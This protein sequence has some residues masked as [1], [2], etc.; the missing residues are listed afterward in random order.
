VLITLY[1][2]SAGKE[3][4][5]TTA[6][7]LT[8]DLLRER[9]I[10]G[11]YRGTAATALRDVTFSAIYFPLFANLNSLGPKRDDGQAVFYWSFLSGCAAGSTAALCVNPMDVIKTRL[12]A[13]NPVEGVAY[14]GVADCIW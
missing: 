3:V 7:Q 12:Q 5:Q 9:G 1:R 4:V 10:L 8:R 14:N 6:L 13:I 2:F 11:L